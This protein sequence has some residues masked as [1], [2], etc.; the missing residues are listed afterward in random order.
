LCRTGYGCELIPKTSNHSLQTKRS[1]YPGG[2]SETS[3]NSCQSVARGVGYKVN[4]FTSKWHMHVALLNKN[5]CCNHSTQQFLNDDD[6][7]NNNNNNIFRLKMF[8][9]PQA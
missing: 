6:D 1:F 9:H 4:V 5:E 3:I 8:S 7:D 2:S